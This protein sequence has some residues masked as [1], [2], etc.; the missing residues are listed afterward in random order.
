MTPCS[1]RTDG[2]TMSLDDVINASFPAYVCS[3]VEPKRALPDDNDEA[4]ASN[5][6]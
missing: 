4:D 5:C 3:P 2:I 1:S 6:P